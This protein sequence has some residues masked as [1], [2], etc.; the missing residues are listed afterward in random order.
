MLSLLLTTLFLVDE[1]KV[2]KIIFSMGRSH[3]R[4]KRLMALMTY[5]IVTDTTNKHLQEIKFNK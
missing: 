1:N 3:H 2:Q 4:F 5:C